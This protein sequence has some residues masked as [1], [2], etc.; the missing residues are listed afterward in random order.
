MSDV[1]YQRQPQVDQLEAERANAVAYGNEPRVAA[2]DK[3]LAGHGV[4]AKAAEE[5]KAASDDGE[6][7]RTPPK[8]RSSRGPAEKTADGA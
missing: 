5:R 3:Q 1:P 7:R 4:K 6:A 8:G 2:I